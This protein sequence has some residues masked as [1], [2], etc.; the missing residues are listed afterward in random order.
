MNEQMRSFRDLN[1]NE[2]RYADTAAQCRRA[3]DRRAITR[4]S[5]SSTSIRITTRPRPFKEIAQYIEDPVMR[6]ESK[7]QGMS[8]GGI[9]SESA[10]IRR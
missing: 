2:L 8:R 4:I 5:S 9:T 7:Y 10:P 1:A 3:G 6:Q